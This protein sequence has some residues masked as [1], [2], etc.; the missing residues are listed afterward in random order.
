MKQHLLPVIL[1]IILVCTATEISGWANDA[2]I[3]PAYV[4]GVNVRKLRRPRRKL[5]K[6]V[7]SMEHR[8]VCALCY[9]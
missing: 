4:C 1:D 3:L 9:F 2:L 8:S 7:W 6:E 5:Y